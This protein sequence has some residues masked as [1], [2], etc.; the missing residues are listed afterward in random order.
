MDLNPKKFKQ[1]KDHL[2]FD[3]F[4]LYTKNSLG[5]SKNKLRSLS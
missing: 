5:E 2:F 1:P 3:F 4:S